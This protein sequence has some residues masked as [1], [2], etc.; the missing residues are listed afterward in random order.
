M[1][2]E[3]L[4]TLL[5]IP[6]AIAVLVYL[7]FGAFNMYHLLRFGAKSAG[8]Y[9]LGFLFIFITLVNLI[10]TIILVWNVDWRNTVE[11]TPDLNI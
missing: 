4:P 11:I 7:I 6:Y 3:I 9:F 8:T 1:T 2:V 5:I 10:I